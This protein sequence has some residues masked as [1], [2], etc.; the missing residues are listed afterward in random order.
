[1]RRVA[2]LALALFVASSLSG[3]AAGEAAEAGRGR[4]VAVIE[5]LQNRYELTAPEAERRLEI[6]AAAGQLNQ[7]L[8][9]ERPN[10]FAGLWLNV[11]PGPTTVTAA[12]T[13]VTPELDE[14]LRGGFE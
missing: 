5:F 6:E 1:M 13:E 8:V 3:T 4:R 7:R 12:F 2:A 11:T 14:D 9:A 10:T